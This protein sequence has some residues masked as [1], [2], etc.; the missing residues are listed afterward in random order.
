MLILGVESP[1]GEKH[2]VAAAF[3]SACGKTN[4]AMLIPPPAFKGWKVTTIGDD[5]AWIKPGEDGRFCAI[6]PE[7]GFF[8]V[9][10]GTSYET[11]PNAMET[12]DAQHDLHQRGADPR[13]RRVVGGH[14]QGSRPRSSSTGRARTG[15]PRT[16]GRTAA[17][18][19]A[20]FT[21]A[22]AQCPSI[23]PAVGRPGGR[24]DRRVHLRRAALGHG[25][26]GDRSADLGGG[27]LHGRDPGL[28]NHRGD[29]GKVGVVRRDPFAMLP[30]AAT[31]SATTSPLARDGQGGREAAADLQRQ[32]VPQ[33]RRRQVPLAGL[34]REHARAAMDRRALPRTC[35][36]GR[37]GGRPRPVVPGSQLVAGRVRS[38]RV[39]PR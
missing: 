21:V 6:N 37:N 31:T 4:F 33:G 26:A 15:R 29:T 9:A 27:R 39:S 1:E 11:N 14:D 36:C 17:H 8:G 12:I 10:P 24:A 3:P 20:R 19:N 25:A 7:A 13:G 35:A 2:Y 5:I 30:S 34:R 18:P 22:G 28:G 32:L 38:P 23:D 16:A